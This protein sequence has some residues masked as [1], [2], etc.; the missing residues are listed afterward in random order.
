MANLSL[1]NSPI[2]IAVALAL[3][4]GGAA[5]IIATVAW[6]ARLFHVEQRERCYM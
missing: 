4:V 3:V 5:L 6:V 1:T 2:M